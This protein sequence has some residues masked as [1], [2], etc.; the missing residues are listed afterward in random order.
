MNP[1]IEIFETPHSEFDKEISVWTEEEQEESKKRIKEQQ[2]RFFPDIGEDDNTNH[3]TESEYMQQM[4]S[5][6]SNNSE[7]AHQNI[8][9]LTTCVE[10][11]Y[12]RSDR[13]S[14][15]ITQ[16]QEKIDELQINMDM[17][18]N[19]INSLTDTLK[20][21]KVHY[22]EQFKNICAIISNMEL[23]F[24]NCLD[25]IEKTADEAYWRADYCYS[26]I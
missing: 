7:Y 25:R 14:K 11:L 26:R 6:L 15:I 16:Q 10:E 22:D 3:Q 12:E 24:N 5:G 17:S 23:G 4:I 1:Q 20:Q 21:S 19:L 9:R 2:D 18:R 13:Q 8:V